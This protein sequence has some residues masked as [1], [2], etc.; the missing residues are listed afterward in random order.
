MGSDPTI[1]SK[2]ATGTK[3]TVSH[4]RVLFYPYVVQKS[5]AH[6]RKKSFNMHH[7]VQKGFRGIFIV[8]PQHQ[9]V[10]IVYVPHRQKI[11]SSCDIVC[12][13]SFSSELAYTSQP[14]A[15]VMAVCT[16]VSYKP[17]ATSS[18]EQTGNIITSAQ[19]GEGGVLSETR[20]DA[21]SIDEY[22]ED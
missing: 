11:I 19:F 3:P 17:C 13:D 12:D 18:R 7:Q 21:L 15:E 9:K 4:L 1:P 16:A 10:F 14:Y 6:V 20:D 2:L 5:T 8:I 22:V